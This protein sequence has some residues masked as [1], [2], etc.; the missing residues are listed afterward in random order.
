MASLT[1]TDEYGVDHPIELVAGDNGTYRLAIK[2][3]GGPSTDQMS[4]LINLMTQLIDEQIATNALLT[5]I[6]NAGA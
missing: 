2:D 5:T 1:F 4:M 3:T 6:A